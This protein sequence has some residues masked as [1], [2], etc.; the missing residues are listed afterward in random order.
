MLKNS[1]LKWEIGGIIFISLVGALFHFVFE[2]LGHWEYIGGFFPVNESVWE[3]LKLPYW[4]LIIFSLIEYQYIKEGT[5]NFIV[6]KTLAALISIVII[7]I[8][9]YTYTAILKTEILIIDISSFIVGVAV[10]QLISYKILTISKVPKL[11]IIF[12]WIIFI[13]LGLI[14]MLFTY[15]PP[16]LPMFQDPLTGLYGIV[17]HN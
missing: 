8:T 11:I 13:T 6:G 15:L 3:H 1:I 14:F 7:I 16:H 10:G 17:E 9:F 12:S 2:W 5:N 4:P